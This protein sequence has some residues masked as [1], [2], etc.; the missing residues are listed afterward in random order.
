MKYKARVH[1][2]YLRDFLSNDEMIYD[3]PFEGKFTT[4]YLNNLIILI[5]NDEFEFET[6]DDPNIY[7]KDLYFNKYGYHLTNED[8]VLHRKEA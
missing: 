8:Y 6:E 2:E 3:P 5:H 1:V 7:I 4:S